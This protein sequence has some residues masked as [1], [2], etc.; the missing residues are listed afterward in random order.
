MFNFSGT[1]KKSKPGDGGYDYNPSEAVFRRR[2]ALKKELKIFV[3]H[4]WDY[5]ADLHTRLA[6]FVTRE[7]DIRVADLSISSDNPVLGPRGGQVR[8]ALIYDKIVEKMDECH[9]VA[10]S[11]KVTHTNN[12]WVRSELTTAVRFLKKPVLFVDHSP[13]QQRRT[14]LMIEL[15]QIG[16]QIYHAGTDDLSLIKE[17]NQIVADLVNQGVSADLS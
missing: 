2:Q 7:A 5:D 6:S 12:Q 9:L 16:G 4:R 14:D 1:D 8:K 13:T 11:S 17:L 10:A 15:A 3:S